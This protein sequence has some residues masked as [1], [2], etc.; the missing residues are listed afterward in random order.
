MYD[1]DGSRTF[2]AFPASMD[3]S[4][5]MEG[6]G[7]IPSQSSLSPVMRRTNSDDTQS[8]ISPKWT[9]TNWSMQLKPGD[10]QG[11]FGLDDTM[12]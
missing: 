2:S 3:G 12:T 9:Q 4:S 5:V 1:P 10:E 8:T 7:T 11:I 6:G